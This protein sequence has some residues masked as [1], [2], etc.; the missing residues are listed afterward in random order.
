MLPLA[1]MGES[2]TVTP[3][4]PDPSSEPVG[5]TVMSAL[6]AELVPGGADGV[7]E[8]AATGIRH[9]PIIASLHA[10]AIEGAGSGDTRRGADGGGGARPEP[11]QHPRP[12]CQ[13]TRVAALTGSCQRQYD[14]S[15]EQGCRWRGSFQRHAFH[16]HRY[17]TR[18]CG[19]GDARP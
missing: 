13:L 9:G 6:C 12:D 14:G 5:V 19:T 1:T 2:T 15:T 7:A 10:V 17:C 18:S 16:R 3:S 11:C 8:A 4:S